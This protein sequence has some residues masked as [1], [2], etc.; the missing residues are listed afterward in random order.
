MTKAKAKKWLRAVNKLIKSYEDDTY[1]AGDCPL[2]KTSKNDFCEDCLWTIYM[3]NV[4]YVTKGGMESEHKDRIPRL[5]R[6]KA[7]L[8]KIIGGK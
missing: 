6:W 2:C 7:R 3:G 1:R 4:C 5:N 8:N